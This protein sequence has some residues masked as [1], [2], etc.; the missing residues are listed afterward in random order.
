MRVSYQHTNVRYGNESTLLRF[1]TDDGTRA[2]VLV[3]AGSGVDLDTVLADDE[4]LN[5]ILLTHAHIDHYRTLAENVRHNAPIYASR[6]TASILEHA[7]PEAQKDNDLGDISDA[8]TA[9]EPIEDWT[10]ILH[11]LEV[12]P[13]SAGHTPGAAGFVIRFRDQTTGQDLWDD[14]RHLLVTG[15]F[16]IRPCA[17]FPGLETAYP[18][19]IDAVFLNVSTNESYTSGL[20]DS[21][22]TV[23]ERAYAGSRVVVATSSLTGTQYATL[24]G[25]VASELGRELPITL[26]GQ[27]AKLYNALELTVPGVETAEVFDRT[28]AVLERGGVTIAGPETPA[29]G[30]AAR[31][32][33][34]I[35]DDPASVF[36]QLVTGDA[37][38]V[39]D[40]G[41]TT[42]YV[43]LRNHPSVE[44]IDAF[45]RDLA[46]KQVVIKH[47]TGDTLNR[48]QRRFDHCFTWGTNDEAV[49]HLY[50]DGEWQ[51]PSWIA[52]STASQIRRRQWEASQNRPVDVGGTL[53]SVERDGID[54]EAAGVDI[55]TL[56]A[57]FSRSST[58]PY[59]TSES[60]TEMVTETRTETQPADTRTDAGHQ[61]DDDAS[62]ETEVLERLAAIEA[63]LDRSEKTVQA[64]VLTD[65]DGEQFLR[66]LEDADIESQDIVEVVISTDG[67]DHP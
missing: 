48:F 45:V 31:L 43:E 14:T 1:T 44:S 39:T 58:D 29:T 9:L 16:T 25:H 56:E 24:V 52:E 20:N 8:L 21:L 18:F 49:H 28:A 41:C 2:C 13:V 22:Q 60:E 67:T 30:S 38:A 53:S 66:L 40:A 23:L 54:L 42:R 32:L 34:S 12:V 17:G 50:Q 57:V 35:R 15:D 64:R 46:P 27:A 4:Y 51:A 63:K 6:A 55:E 62:L 7:L 65:N 61:S 26:V 47:A 33:D 5:A 3:D 11:G 59:A 19:D 10:S 36:V 37:S